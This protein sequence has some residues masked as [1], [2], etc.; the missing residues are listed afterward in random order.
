MSFVCA[1]ILSFL[2]LNG[3][4]RL[5]QIAQQPEVVQ[6]QGEKLKVIEGQIENLGKRLSDFQTDYD[7]LKSRYDEQE[8]TVS[9]LRTQYDTEINKIND[10]LVIENDMIQA[11]MKRSKPVIFDSTSKGFQRLDTD[12]G[13]LLISIQKISPYQDGHKLR[14]YIGNPWMCKFAGFTLKAK[15]GEAFKPKGKVTSADWRKSLRSKDE[16]FTEI[17]EPGHWNKI[18]I[19]FAPSKSEQL[20]HIE[21]EL[22]LN[23]V[24]LTSDH[25]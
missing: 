15:W 9:N 20:E 8:Q 7:A 25:E 24:L 11:M 2:L 21:I 17:L 3:C 23:Q 6:K 16:K 10:A 13:P 18:D 14:L 1:V 4:D 22:E 5:T 19:V 12:L